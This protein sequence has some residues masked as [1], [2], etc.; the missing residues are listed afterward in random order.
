MWINI[1]MYWVCEIVWIYKLWIRGFSFFKYYRIEYF[2]LEE[3]YFT[4]FEFFLFLRYLRRLGSCRILE[5]VCIWRIEKS[6]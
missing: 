2:N 4:D 6:L 3:N 5:F 1:Y